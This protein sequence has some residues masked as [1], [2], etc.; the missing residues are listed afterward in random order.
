LII[1]F[2]FFPFLTKA[3]EFFIIKFLYPNFLLMPTTIYYEFVRI[4]EYIYAESGPGSENTE[5]FIV[6]EI[7]EAL[8]FICCLIYLE[9]LE[10]R[11]CGLD[12]NLKKNITKRAETESAI[13]NFDDPLYDQNNNSNIEE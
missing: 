8:E 5:K 1:A 10:L 9:I 6:F 3:C 2:L 11:F 13:I 7:S 4:K 12:K